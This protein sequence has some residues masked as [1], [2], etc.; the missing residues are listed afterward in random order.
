MK[1]SQYV[2]EYTTGERVLFKD[3]ISEAK[4]LVVEVVKMHK[5]RIG[6]EFEDVFHFMQLWL[7]W[8][9]SVD[10]DIWKITQH[11]VQKFM[12]RKKVWNAIYVFVGLPEN[13]SGYVGNYKKVEKVINHLQ[14]FGVKKEQ[15]EEAYKRIVAEGLV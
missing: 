5:G 9:F 11:S 7:Y 6:E 4:E 12:E 13:I 2:K 8:Q 1:I 3:I 15:A 10:G 14:K